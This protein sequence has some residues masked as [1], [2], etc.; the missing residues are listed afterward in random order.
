[1]MLQ[2]REIRLRPVELPGDIDLA[3]PWYQDAQ[4]LK[5]SQDPGTPA[6]SRDRVA[7]MYRH[8]AAHSEFY[9][10]EV[11]RPDG[12]WHAVGDVG[13]S[14]TSLPIVIGDAF[15]RNRGVGTRVMRLLI[16]QA[17][18]HG[19][20][21]LQV[22]CVWSH[23]VASQK[24][25]EKLGFVRIGDETGNNLKDGQQFFRYRLCLIGSSVIPARSSLPQMADDAG[26][27]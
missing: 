18:R 21:A 15:Y 17:R 11:E 26:R 22:G 16:Q 5:D 9:I 6:M 8:Q 20:Q 1:M 10:I 2:D 3:L 14:P 27:R 4:V 25:F 23:N 13:L 7:R 24:L 19:W 12:R